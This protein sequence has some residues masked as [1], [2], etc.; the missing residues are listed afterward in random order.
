MVKYKKIYM[1]SLKYG[2]DE[3]VECELCG[4]QADDIHHIKR[5]GEGGGDELENLIAVC[6]ECHNKCHDGVY[7]KKELFDR[8][9]KFCEKR[10]YGFNL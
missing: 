2:I 7:E 5:R 9:L 1:N 4:G 10:K 3:P 8:H 6:R